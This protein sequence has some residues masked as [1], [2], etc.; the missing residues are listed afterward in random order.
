MYSCIFKVISILLRIKQKLLSICLAL[1]YESLKYNYP[2]IDRTV[3]FGVSYP[4]RIRL[5]HPKSIRIGQHTIINPDSVLDCAG[6][7][8]IGMYCHFGRGLT[9]YST[10]HDFRSDRFI[11]YGKNDIVK[12]V[13]IEDFVWIGANVSIC[14]GIIIG[15]GAIIG[16]GAV[17]TKNVDRMAIVGGNPAKLIGN[18]NETEFYKLKVAQQFH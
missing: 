17:V 14:P 2:N 10:N 3:K 5:L 18:R 15:E 4:G 12:P 6:S 11:P 9:I 8:T 1:E 16:M 13:I 7:I